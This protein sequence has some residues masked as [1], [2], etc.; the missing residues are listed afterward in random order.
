MTEAAPVY[1][2]F[3]A[4]AAGRPGPL[5]V[6]GDTQRTSRL[7]VIFRAH[8]AE[9][10][11]L[12]EELEAARPAVLLHCGDLVTWGPSRRHWARFDRLADG[13]RKQGTPFFPV[14]GNHE[15]LPFRGGGDK[16]TAARFPHLAGRRWYELRWGGV[17]A[18]ALDSNFGALGGARVR[19]QLA[20]LDERLAVHD[21]DPGVRGVIAFWHHPPYT[22]SRIV[23]ASASTDRAFAARVKAA[24]KAVAVFNGHC[25]AY[26][27]F[28][29]DGLDFFVTGGGGGPLQPL[30][31]RPGKRRF[32]DLF[33][34][35][36]ARRFLHF[37]AIDEEPGGLALR[38]V[39]IPGD[40]GAAEVVDRV[41]LPFR[42]G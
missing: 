16:H 14:L 9:Q 37:V 11:R 6:V 5:V 32:D 23:R 4:L 7:E 18:V 17:V 29:S 25:H 10:A 15:H 27:H 33:A 3:D 30:E 19:A 1:A 34:W 12:F 20:W 39:R 2:G 28:V 8:D 40:A 36:R 35:P 21:Q 41:S 22:N 42:A 31:T 13:L 24:R 38:V 26:E